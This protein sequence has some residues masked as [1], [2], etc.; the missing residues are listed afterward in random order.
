[1]YKDG[2][3]QDVWNN[4]ST[5]EKKAFTEA[6]CGARVDGVSLHKLDGRSRDIPSLGVGDADF[7]FGIEQSTLP[8]PGAFKET[9]QAIELKS[10]KDTGKS[11]RYEQALNAFGDIDGINGKEDS[12]F[13]Y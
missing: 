3:D 10:T 8:Q 1:M 5:E 2:L 6:L 4:G 13:T 11:S 12:G 7:E 9:Y